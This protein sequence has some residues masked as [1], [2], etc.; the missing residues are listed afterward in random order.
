MELL[1]ALPLPAVLAALGAFFALLAAGVRIPTWQAD[2]PFEL[3][4][5][6]QQVACGVTATLLFGGAIF[7]FLR[8]REE[9]EPVPRAASPQRKPP[10]P[11]R[12]RADAFLMR[13]DD[14]S[15]PSFAELVRHAAKV[16]IL[17]RTAVNL[18]SSY[19]REIEKLGE[20]NCPVEFLFVSPQSPV[21]K[22]LYGANSEVYNNNISKSETHLR[23]L[24]KKFPSTFH[25]KTMLHAPTMSII[26]V[27]TENP[28]DSFAR[29]QLYF[30]HSCTGH[31]RPTFRVD[32]G[33]AWYQV[34]VAEFEELWKNCSQD[35]EPTE[36]HTK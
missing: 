7:V 28:A 17:T 31:D 5:K 21:T 24:R 33:D 10:R 25:A 16:R 32:H 6:G 3:K 20:R 30:L 11:K 34:F 8:K 15:S 9:H 35:W 22:F 19:R 4:E 27:E 29:V 36:Q 12:P 26:I 2:A 13:L 23:E 18:L 14:T 1:K